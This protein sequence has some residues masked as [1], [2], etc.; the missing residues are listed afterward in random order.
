MQIDSYDFGRISIS[1]VTYTADVLVFPDRVESSWWRKEGHRLAFED[2]SSVVNSKPEILIVGT[3]YGGAMTVPGA[4]VRRLREQR[5]E[6]IVATTQK[7]CELFNELSR[8]KRVVA[9]LHLTC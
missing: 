5:I 2:L 4:I 7:A 9:A 1:G 6:T 3:G 8:E